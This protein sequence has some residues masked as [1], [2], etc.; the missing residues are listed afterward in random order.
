V[1]GIT[2]SCGCISQEILRK[3]NHRHGRYGSLEYTLFHKAK[4][5]AK[6]N[7]LPFD[8]TL[9]EIQ[10]PERC[11]VLDIPLFKHTKNICD[12]SPTLDRIN[13]TKGYTA[14][15]THVISARANRLKSDSTADELAAIAA[16]LRQVENGAI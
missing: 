3:R 8:L 9:E 11:P 13:N 16:Y 15:N 14:R 10:V 12:N 5:R 2:K 7:G 1:K 6:R 4:A